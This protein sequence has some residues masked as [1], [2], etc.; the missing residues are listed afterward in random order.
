MKADI[1]AR[2]LFENNIQASTS[3]APRNLFANDDQQESLGQA[4]KYAIPRIGEDILNSAYQGAQHIPEYWEKAKSEVP[5]YFNPMNFL[6]HPIERGKQTLAGLLEA[7]Q[8]INHL[9]RTLAQYAANRLHLISPETANKVPQAPDLDQATEQYIGNPQHPGEALARGLGRHIDLLAGGNALNELIPHLTKRGATRTLNKAQ[10]LAAERE[11][12]TLNVNPQLIEDAKQFFPNLLQRHHE[13]L[14][15]A[16]K[17]DYNSLFRLQ[18]ELGQLAGQQKKS[19]FSPTERIKGRAGLEARDNLLNDIH[20]NLQSLGHKD[21]SDLL[22]Q[23]QK[24]FRRYSKFKKYRNAL[25]VAGAA[26]VAPKNALTD[27]AR[28]LI[29]LGGH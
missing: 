18:S 5:A 17:G 10:K 1:M 13:D 3:R 14:L 26:Y 19:W 2:N 22:R 11:I 29:S 27:L 23:G 24:E 21:I 16:H 12:G 9:P 25:G 28:K 7:G 8:G 15:A 6:G 4:A 20:K